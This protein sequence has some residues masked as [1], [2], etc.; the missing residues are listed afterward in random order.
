MRNLEEKR[1]STLSL[2]HLNAGIYL[3]R[4][5]GENAHFTSRITLK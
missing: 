5:T 4:V 2:A 3:V 1:S